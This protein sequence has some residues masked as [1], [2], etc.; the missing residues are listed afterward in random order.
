MLQEIPCPV[1]NLRTEVFYVGSAPH[2]V[3]EYFEVVH[4]R[5]VIPLEDSPDVGVGV[6]VLGV[7]DVCE[8][9]PCKDKFTGLDAAG[10]IVRVDSDY[11][12]RVA[13]D[14]SGD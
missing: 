1:E 8:D 9:G 4:D 6:E 5:S 12:C 11:L 13:E 14:G 10:N 7:G 3:G 2:V